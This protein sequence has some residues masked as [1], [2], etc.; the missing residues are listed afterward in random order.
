MN[1]EWITDRLPKKKDSC[2]GYVW[3]SFEDN[4]V[5]VWPY[6]WEYITLGMPWMPLQFPEPYLRPKRYRV[7]CHHNGLWRV[8]DKHSVEPGL[9]N[10]F[11]TREAA[12]RIAAIYEEVMP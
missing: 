5:H 3:A 8:I 10:L 7:D 6:R 12:E 2:G 11:S 1:N 9:D 4:D